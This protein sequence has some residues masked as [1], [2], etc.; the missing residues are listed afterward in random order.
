MTTPGPL[1]GVGLRALRDGEADAARWAT[2]HD[3][4]FPLAATARALGRPL[5]HDA[6]LEEA[7]AA[8]ARLEVA[9]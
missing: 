8:A 9:G 7:K 2:W 4:R 6:C 3:L 1:G 5:P